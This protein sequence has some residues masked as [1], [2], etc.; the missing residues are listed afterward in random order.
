MDT[1]ETSFAAADSYLSAA[2]LASI[3][4]L[5]REPAAPARHRLVQIA[6]D[7]LGD[8]LG[9]RERVLVA[10]VL[11][12]LVRE[13][14]E[15][16]RHS[17][18]ERLAANSNA[19]R[20]LILFLANDDIAVARPVLLGS[21]VLTDGDLVDIIRLRSPFHSRTIAQRPTVSAIVGE[22]LVATGDSQTMMCLLQNAGAHLSP[23]AALSLAEVARSVESMQAPLLQRA[24]IP[25]EV[26]TA[27]YWHVSDDLRRH[28]R[29]RFAFE[30][31][32]LERALLSSLQ[33]LTGGN[34]AAYEVSPEMLDAAERLA[35]SG[36]LS[37]AT[38][39]QVLRRGQMQLFL[40]LFARALSLDVRAAWMI[41]AAPQ[42][43]KL[44]VAAKALGFVKSDF[45][46]LF[47][48][49]RSA[50]SGEQIA[51]P[52]EL[53]RVL[54]FYERVTPDFA[55]SML[56]GWRSGRGAIR[57]SLDLGWKLN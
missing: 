5:A 41:V 43:E 36:K 53:S 14:Q 38:M 31:Q 45:A 10:E 12:R 3:A 46:S 26:A 56:K 37:H 21:S 24:E 54:Q 28:I 39:I 32:Q 50:R 29:S 48:L 9:D 8:N 18:A 22:T 47:L 23:A 17:V 44:A 35:E 49:C 25:P 55:A 7:L 20:E 27:I 42:G 19:P 16:L 4:R 15:D 6:G 1:V 2:E 33:E 30:P 34:R 40:A 11:L 52:R 13:A 51:D 57:A